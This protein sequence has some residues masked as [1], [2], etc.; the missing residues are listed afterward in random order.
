MRRSIAAASLVTGVVTTALACP[1]PA[2]AEQSGTTPVTLSVT[3][4]TLD[5]SVPTGPVALGSVGTSATPQTIS[6]QLGNVTVTDSRG[7][8]AGWV[9]TANGTDFVGPQNISVS[10]PG[11]SSYTTPA[12]NTT[13]TVNVTPSNLSPL[14]PPGPVQTATG[15]S[16]NNTATWNP[17]I[18][19]TIPANALAGTYNASITHSVA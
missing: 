15:V 8:T 7:G 13:G 17:I 11:S 14:Y 19:V 5:I 6:N 1:L 16:G 3:S 4:G 9:V 10:A 2:S 18:S 12:A